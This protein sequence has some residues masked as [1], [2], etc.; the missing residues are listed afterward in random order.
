MI[1]KYFLKAIVTNRNLWGW[2][3]LFMAFWLVLGAFVFSTNMPAQKEIELTYTSS[4]YGIIALYSFA[5]IAISVSYTVYYGSSSLAYSFRY[6]KLKPLGYF[7]SLLAAASV[8]AIVISTIMLLATYSLFSYRFGINLQP[9]QPLAALALSA[10]AGAFMMVLAMLLVLI[11]VNYAGVKNINFIS[12]VPLILS[13]IFGFGQLYANLPVA[14]EYLSPFTAISSL[15]FTSY[16]NLEM[17]VHP[18]DPSS[19]YLDWRL[20]LLSLLA[21]IFIIAIA[22]TQLLRRIKPRAIEEARQ[23]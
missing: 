5:S 7:S 8:M 18:L 12:F 15:L 11:V 19:G 6:T 1:F 20:L 16:S 22:D 14:A 10:L 21:W 4:Y 9:A 13:Y 2:G 3:V 17:P 23:V